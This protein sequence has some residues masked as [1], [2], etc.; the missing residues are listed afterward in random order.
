MS[1]LLEKLSEKQSMKPESQQNMGTSC[2]H[3]PHANI[4]SGMGV[5][6]W[7]QKKWKELG[8]NDMT[9]KEIEKEF[10][11]ED[12]EE[13]WD[14]DLSEVIDSEEE[15]DYYE[16]DDLDYGECDYEDELNVQETE[17]PKGKKKYDSILDWDREDYWAYGCSAKKLL[18]M[19]FADM[20]SIAGLLEVV[21]SL[22]LIGETQQ[23]ELQGNVSDISTKLKN[24]AISIVDRWEN[25]LDK[26]YE[27]RR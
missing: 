24:R 26:D 27:I 17:L 3:C 12:M 15:N 11:Y 8:D 13:D 6:S 2:L 22:I 4:H 14:D 5:W 10:G 9:D 7:L 18:E 1:T 21:D 19:Q 23:H 20:M 25:F 16:D